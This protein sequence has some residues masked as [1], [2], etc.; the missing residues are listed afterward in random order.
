MEAVPMT[1]TRAGR[2]HRIGR[3]VGRTIVV[4]ILLVVVSPV[5]LLPKIVVSRIGTTVQL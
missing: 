5:I 1:G 4:A 2:A 3:V